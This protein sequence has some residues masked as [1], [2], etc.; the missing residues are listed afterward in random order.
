MKYPLITGP[1]A[2]NSFRVKIASEKISQKQILLCM[3]G[4]RALGA[5]EVGK[6]FRK[7]LKLAGLEEKFEV[8]E[9]GC[10]GQCSRAPVLMIEPD[11]FLYGGVVPEDVDEI[12]EATL[13]GGRPIA[14]LS[15]YAKGK[16]SAAAEKIPFYRNQEKKVLRNCGR[17]DPRKLESAVAE[18]AYKAA[19][20]ALCQMTPDEIINEMSASGLRGRGGAG[21]PTGQKWRFCRKAEGSRKFLVCNADEGD[22]GAFMDRALLEGTPHQVIEGMIIAAFAIGASYGFIYVRAEYPIAVEHITIAVSQAR[23]AGL[24]GENIMGSGYSFDIEIRMGAG[25]F[26]CG[27][28]TALIASLEGERGMPSPRPPFP[29]VKGYKGMPTNIN[30]VETL[31]N[32]PL[33][34]ERGGQW[35][36]SRGT[37]AGRGTK[38][39][40]LAGKVV[41]TGLV[42]VPFGTTLRQIVFDIGGGIPDGREFKAAQIGGPS[43]GCI[44]AEFLDLPLDY[45]SVKEIGAIIGSGGLIVMDD[46]TCMVDVARFFLEF[47]QKESCGK[48]VPCR[49]G[50]RQMVDILNS[51][52][53][54]RGLPGDIKKLEELAL[55][56]KKASLCGLGQTAP[57]PVLTTIRYFRDEYKEHI[58]EHRCPA[59]VCKNL[60]EYSIIPEACKACGKCIEVC[61]TDAIEGS[62]KVPHMINTARCIRCGEC[63]D[64]CPF[65]AVVVK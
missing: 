45:E 49:V 46:R 26:V 4:C 54:G 6:A 5:E 32:V 23:A 56:V 39:F 43:G 63:M 21:F 17:V 51:I 57:N 55:V 29:A 1:D 22:P 20:R 50:T 48:C 52:C 8:I 36:S 14:R 16:T 27:E 13:K 7:K 53:R 65:G 9:T 61:S 25:A 59:G 47:V 28:E 62:K 34:I 30:N 2:L 60:I 44:P 41:N 12:I 58:A 31:A 42:E 24:L 19:V 38:I 3:T 35:Y 15:T 64:V 10:H 40:A 11:H 33:I 18:G 37:Q